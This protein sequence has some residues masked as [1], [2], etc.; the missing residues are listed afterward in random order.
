MKRKLLVMAIAVISVALALCLTACND[1]GDDKNDDKITV[2]DGLQFISNS[3]GTC[4]VAMDDDSISEITVPSK[5]PKGDKVTAI[6]GEGFKN[7]ANLKSIVLPD[8]LTDIKEAAFFGCTSLSSIVIPDSVRS[9]EDSAFYGCENLKEIT[10]GK[11]IKQFGDLAFYGCVNLEKVNVTDLSAWCNATFANLASN[12]FYYSHTVC[13]DGEAVSE[14]VIP[15]GTVY[16]S[17]RAFEFCTSLTSVTVPDSV[18]DIGWQAFRGCDG[19]RSISIPFVGNLADSVT[20]PYFGYI[21]GARKCS[22]NNKHVP[23]SLSSVTI[24]GTSPIPANAFNGCTGIKD[25]AI[26]ESVRGVD[27]EAFNGCE[28]LN[29]TEYDNAFYLGNGTDTYSVLVWTKDDEI[30]SCEIHKDTKIIAD[31]AFADCS[32]LADI[33]IPDDV[34]Y[35]GR[36]AFLQCSGLTS[37]T[38]PF[39]GASSSITENSHFGFIFGAENHGENRS[40]VPQSLTTVTISGKYRIGEN[41]FNGCESIT[42]VN[43]LQAVDGVGIGAFNGCSSLRYYVND[44][45]Y[46]IGNSNNPYLVLVKSK[47]KD[48]VTCTVR[49]TTEIIADGA[50][51][52]CTKLASIGI[53]DNVKYIGASAFSGCTELKTA[54]F[55]NTE[56]WTFTENP[57]SNLDNPQTAARYLTYTYVSSPIIRK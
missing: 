21:F 18:I 55:N 13:I 32:K 5:S 2:A 35:V 40:N 1:N 36:D 4:Y 48:L 52:S 23:A 38:L 31:R 43:I 57:I 3:D 7:L 12:P 37:I 42:K 30:T 44:N 10:I 45:A 20:Q 16:I 54:I 11:G 53:T 28:S 6:Y 19:L 29:Y 50:F 8:T 14:L 41:A 33:T 25:I 51:S 46:Y 34:K 56:G 39:V 26:L 47:G 15:E 27:A 24:T 9:I 49:S 17:P 22:D